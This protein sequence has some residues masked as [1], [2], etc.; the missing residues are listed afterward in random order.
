MQT[1]CLLL[2]FFLFSFFEKQNKN[3]YEKLNLT[4][5]QAKDKGILRFFFRFLILIRFHHCSH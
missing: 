1:V 4:K 5:Q 3:I 2:A